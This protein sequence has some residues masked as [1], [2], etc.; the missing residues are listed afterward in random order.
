MVPGVSAAGHVVG[1][2]A[3]ADVGE[4][5]VEADRD[6]FGAAHLDPVVLRGVVAGRE[7]HPGQPEVAGREVEPVGRAQPDQHRVGAGPVGPARERLRHPRRRRPHVVPDDDPFSPGHRDER[8]PDALGQHLV[9]LVRHRAPHVVR[10]E[11]GA[12]VLPVGGGHVGSL[13]VGW[14]GRS[15]VVEQRAPSTAV[16]EQRVVAAASSDVVEQRAPASVSR[17]RLAAAGGQWSKA[18]RREAAVRGPERWRWSRSRAVSRSRQRST[19]DLRIAL[20]Q[21]NVDGFHS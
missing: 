16:V 1:L 7:H 19:T 2:D 15:P 8:R 12:Q 18:Q 9:D 21:G 20:F 10:L 5:G 4:P 11:D 14:R 3:V 13:G 6:R 17:S